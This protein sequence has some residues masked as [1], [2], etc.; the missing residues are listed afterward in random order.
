MRKTVFLFIVLALLLTPLCISA[1]EVL[2][3]ESIIQLTKAGISEGLIVNMVNSQPGNYKLGA[4]DVV[5]LKKQGVT[6]KV[7]AAMLRRASGAPSETSSSQTAT[8]PNGYPMEIGVY[9]K[10][11]NE[12]LEILPE[13]VNWKSGGVLK[14]IASMGVV[15][16]DIN[17]HIEGRQSRSR[18]SSP[19][20]FVVVAPEGVAITEYQLL[21]L[22]QHSDNREFRTVTGG[23][24]HVKGGATRDLVPFEGKKISPHYFSV[25]LTGLTKGEYGLL[26][27]GG[28]TS[29]SSAATLGKIYTFGV[30]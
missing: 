14:S 21:K 22:N 28:V 4:D 12:W 6:D 13:V 18:V 2:T 17:G 15:K 7:I 29:A 26:P 27:P 1:Q 30:E 8:A 19:L 11:G 5:E 10:K 9:L 24:F 23:V 20:E 3:N 16:G 25:V